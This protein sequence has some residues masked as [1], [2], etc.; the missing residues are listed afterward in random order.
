MGLVRMLVIVGCGLRDGVCRM[1]VIVGY[2][3]T[4]GVGKDGFGCSLRDELC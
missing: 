3:L 4:D 2:G 1:F